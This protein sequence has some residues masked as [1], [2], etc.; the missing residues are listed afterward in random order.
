MITAIIGKESLLTKHL[1]IINKKSIVFSSR[2]EEEVEKII[3]FI[4]NSN[5]KINLIMNNFYPS[6]KINKIN[7]LDYSRFYEQSIVYNANIFSKINPKKIN[8]IIYS[9][10]SAVYNSIRKDYKPIVIYG[11]DYDTID[12]TCVRDYIHVCDLVEAHFEAFKKI[13]NEK[14]SLIYNLANEKG[15]SVLEIIKVC[16]K[17]T[18]KKVNFSFDKKRQGD[19]SCLIADCQKARNEIFWNP[20]KSDIENIVNTAWKWHRSLK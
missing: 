15:F 17:I 7:N 8:R 11:N 13:R 20:S 1:K 6:A 16:E 4:N 14:K 9:S 5:K 10:S 12:G 3:K 18:K 2:T 19:P